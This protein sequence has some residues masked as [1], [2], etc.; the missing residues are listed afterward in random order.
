MPSPPRA[1]LLG[2]I[3]EEFK[4]KKE[5]LAEQLHAAYTK[6]LDRLGHPNETGA[7]PLR[8]TVQGGIGTAAEDACCESYYGADGTGWAT[9]FLLVPEVTNVDD[10]HLQKLCAATNGDVYLSDSSPFGL[11]F[12]NLRTSASEEARRR[13]IAEDRPGSPVRQGLRHAVQHGIH[14]APDLHGVAPVPE[15]QTGA[16]AAKKI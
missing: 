11:P 14:R 6:A 13:R 8:I 5:S 12:W 2:P 3:L 10:E 9:P 16:S 4:Q 15:T 1:F 7:S